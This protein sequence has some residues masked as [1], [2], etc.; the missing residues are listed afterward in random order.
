MN[1]L[2]QI[3]LH[4]VVEI[5]KLMSLN[6]LHVDLA[7]GRKWHAQRLLTSKENEKERQLSKDR[8][9]GSCRQGQ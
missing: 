2:E 3:Y 7:G 5:M 6:S 8:T 1:V 9:A 4:K